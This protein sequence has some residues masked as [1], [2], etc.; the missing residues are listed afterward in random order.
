MRKPLIVV[1]GSNVLQFCQMN[2]PT[3]IV[4]CILINPFLSETGNQ[5]LLNLAENL[6]YRSMMSLFGFETLLNLFAAMSSSE[7]SEK[8]E[9][10]LSNFDLEVSQRDKASSAFWD[11]F[12]AQLKQISNVQYSIQK[13]IRKPFRN[14]SAVILTAPESPVG[15]FNI[16]IAESNQ[17][18]L[19]NNLALF[20]E[21]TTIVLIEKPF[22]DSANEIVDQI[23][24]AFGASRNEDKSSWSKEHLEDVQH[25]R[26]QYATYVP[27]YASFGHDHSHSHDHGHDH[28]HS[29]S[30]SHSH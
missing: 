24:Q 18:I 28:S 9:I 15:L 29:H 17:E 11:S 3:E 22:F 16:L 23:R 2:S 6:S 1:G 19:R 26:H 7:S 21:A 25:Q 5:R 13:N 14:I 4:G 20:D 27:N 12:S 10:A 30:H 8:P